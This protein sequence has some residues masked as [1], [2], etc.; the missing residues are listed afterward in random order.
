MILRIQTLRHFML[1]VP[2]YCVLGSCSVSLTACG[3]QPTSPSSAHQAAEQHSPSPDRQTSSISGSKQDSSTERSVPGRTSGEGSRIPVVVFF[4]DSLT[5][6]LGVAQEEAFPAVLRRTFE[7]EGHPFRAINAG[8]SGDTTAGGLSRLEWILAQHPD[9]I[10]LELGANDGLRGLPLDASEANL[11][12]MI[13][14]GREAGAVMILAG[15]MLPTNYGPEYTNR[16]AGLF[17]ALAKEMKVP[18]VP[19]LLQGVATRPELTQPDGLHPTAKG[20][21]R[22]AENVRPYLEAVLQKLPAHSR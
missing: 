6:G 8:I 22:V 13:Q 20:Y 9:V 19:F 15:M 1:L 3:E 16:F 17:P 5:A 18:L 21:E 4:G 12:R 2:T 11:R 7:K 14:K 10:V